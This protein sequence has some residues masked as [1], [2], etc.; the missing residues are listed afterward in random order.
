MSVVRLLLDAEYVFVS[1]AH[2]RLDFTMSS[3]TKYDLQNANII[4]NASSNNKVEAVW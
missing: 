3:S 1:L 2:C 4:Y